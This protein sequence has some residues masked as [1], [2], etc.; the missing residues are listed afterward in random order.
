[1]KILV[2]HISDI[3]LKNQN[4]IASERLKLVPQAVRNAEV[5]VGTVVVIASGDIAY[6]G[7][8][9]EYAIAKEDW[10]SL[11]AQLQK[12]FTA[13]AIHF[14][15]VPGNHDC[16]LTGNQ[17][18]RDIL[19]EKVREDY[20]AFDEQVVETCSEVQTHF[21]T[22]LE[23]TQTIK[24]AQAPNAALFNY[25][26]NAGSDI[27][28][29]RCYNT[30]LISTI[31]ERPGQLT[32]PLSLLGKADPKGKYNYAISVLHHPYNWLMPNIGR[33]LREHVERSSDLILT[34]HEHESDNYRKYS[35]TSD[36]ENDYME[37]AVFQESDE[38]ENSGFNA[39][40]IDMAS[41]KQKLRS[42]S[43]DGT[44]Y[45]PREK[46][47]WTTW[48]RGGHLVRKDFLITPEF[49]AELEDPGAKFE[50]PARPTGL[51]LEDIYVFPAI[52]EVIVE[53]KQQPTQPPRI[54][55]RELLKRLT[56]LGKTLI[57]GRERSGKTTLAKVIF[58]EHYRK[59]AVPVLLK[60]EDITQKTL[61]LEDFEKLVAAKLQAQYQNPKLPQFEQLGRDQTV[62]ILDDFDHAK[63]NPR[64]RL[65][66]LDTIQKR[67]DRICVLSDSFIQIEEIAYRELGTAVLE[68]YHQFELQEFGHF[69]RSKIIEQWYALGSEYASNPEQIDRKIETAC[70]LIDSFLDKSYLPAYPIFILT[71][72]Q[73]IDTAHPLNTNAGSYGHIYEVL[74]TKSLA[75]GDK[76]TNIDTKATYLAEMAYWMFEHQTRE[77]TEPQYRLFHAKYEE[78]YGIRLPVDRLFETLHTSAILA[79]GGQEF[80]FKYP[81]YYY[82]F[83]ARYL[84]DNIQTQK[85]K[86]Q[87]KELLAKLHKED[88]SN[89]W[90]IL[91][92]LSKDPFLV[93]SIVDHAKMLFIEIKP[94]EFSNDI[95]FLN[96]FY[97]LIPKI[98]L[99]DKTP[100]QMREIRRKQLEE[101]HRNEQEFL[102]DEASNEQLI[103]IITKLNAAFRTIEVL[104]QIVRNFPGSIVGETKYLLVKEC[105]ELG[106]RVIGFILNMWRE[107]GEDIIK[108]VVD[109]ILEKYPN[110]ESKD[111]L[112]RKIKA[113]LYTFLEAVAFN[114][115]K[116][117][118]HAVGASALTETY[119]KVGKA[120]PTRSVKLINASVKLDTIGFPKKEIMDL[121]QE[122]NQ[123]VFCQEL[124]RHLVVHHFYLFHTD[125]KIKQTICDEMGIEFKQLR[126]R[127]LARTDAKRINH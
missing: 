43:W 102:E 34:G 123:N 75:T 67:F 95:E 49:Q 94:A 62:I 106:L 31:P 122:M 69:L 17:S 121:Y 8:T 23:E 36:G 84:R 29:V 9:E 91:T 57:I 97:S 78:K 44:I 89:I 22:F 42:Y 61:Q 25:E 59:G 46:D 60:G 86:D 64:G 126:N 116:R 47:Q 109:L 81:Y 13:A 80:R 108:Q 18:V 79:G 53:G 73:G 4:N 90:I 21:R 124:V 114:M 33:R 15:A 127:E 32:Y 125:H 88:H 55:G 37:G 76:T 54:E 10:K 7:K 41:Q 20:A 70:S 119:E 40:W 111:E 99:E 72:L 100:E 24:P 105:Y 112:T 30:A 68:H 56:G 92:H 117:I 113:F 26:I 98:V 77:L 66:L 39:V 87:I 63:I 16:C 82:Y 93:D 19:I 12:E 35:Y 107:G 96:G 118:S 38:P 71:F 1:M 2:L 115:V 3:H 83:V 58:Q 27:L 52:A 5:D 85:I 6:S 65:K 110:L 103:T 51:R 120:M 14:L 50:H 74:V 45:K 101:S 104:G 11:L 48:T 28:L